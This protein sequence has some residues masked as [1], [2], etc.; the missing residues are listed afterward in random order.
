MTLGVHCA[1][2]DSIA[3]RENTFEED[4]DLFGFDLSGHWKGV[5]A[6]VE[7][8]QWR[9]DFTD[10]TKRSREPRGWYLQ[11]RYFIRSIKGMGI[12]LEPVARCEE[13]DQDANTSDRKEKVWTVGANWYAKGHI[14]HPRCELG[15][16]NV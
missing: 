14:L 4:R 11:A 8:N 6:R 7:F 2:K 9:E 5:T 1:I 3:Y 13:Y 15:P 16:H 10:P 12:N